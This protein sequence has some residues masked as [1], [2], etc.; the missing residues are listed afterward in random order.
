MPSIDILRASAVE[1]TARVMQV[2]GMFDLP[3]VDRSERRWR[4]DINL[5]AKWNVGLIV[6]PSGSGK[7]TVA[8][9]LFGANLVQGYEW[10]PDRSL[11]DGFPPDCGIKDITGLLSSVGFSSPPS[12]VRPFAALSNGEQFR[13]TLARAMAEAKG[14]FV[15]DEFTSVVDR[16][17]AKVG[18]VAV[19]KAVRQRDLRFVAVACHY[20]IVEWLEPD[21]VYQPHTAQFDLAAERC[22]RRP[23]IDVEIRRVHPDAWRLFKQ[24]HYLSSEIHRAAVCFV[25]FVWG[26]PAAFTSYLHFPHPNCP[27]FKREHRTVVLPDFQGIGLGNTLS[28]WLGGKLVSEGWRFVSTTSHPAMVRHR[29]KSRLWRVCR[30]LSRAAPMGR[31][32]GNTA[33]RKSISTARLTAGFEFVGE[34]K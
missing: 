22:L 7:S 17:V 24:H 33:L 26:Q 23:K 27:R 6:G 28:E 34:A 31:D 10:P 21:W 8:R 32:T 29:Y 3:P 11:L 15:V 14:I 25:A 5:P 19:A 4:V 1:R 13:V 2:E 18:S 30:E 20:D 9:E 12:W 16:T